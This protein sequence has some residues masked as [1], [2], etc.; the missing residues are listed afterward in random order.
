MHIYKI[1]SSS[2]NTSLLP[3]ALLAGPVC[4]MD[5]GN[6]RLPIK[7]KGKIYGDGGGGVAMVTNQGRSLLVPHGR[8]HGGLI[9][10]MIRYL[11]RSECGK[12]TCR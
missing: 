9:N 4:I 12:F 11:S 3:K 5:T 2:A 8:W 6:L 10:V 7:S 1:S